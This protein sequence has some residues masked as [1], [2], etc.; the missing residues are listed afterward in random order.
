MYMCTFVRIGHRPLS[1]SV[2]SLRHQVIKRRFKGLHQITELKTVPAG[3]R[4][5]WVPAGKLTQLWTVIM[6]LNTMY[7]IVI[8]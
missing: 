7:A 5:R 6:V 4:S 3:F 2:P 8:L 1:A